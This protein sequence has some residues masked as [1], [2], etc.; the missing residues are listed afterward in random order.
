MALS[1]LPDLT[2]LR[3]LRV[4]IV[5]LNQATL[6]VLVNSIPKEMTAIH[7]ATPSTNKALVC[8]ISIFVKRQY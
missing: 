5:D 4:R 7:L 6:D 2:S 1:V 3:V 8:T